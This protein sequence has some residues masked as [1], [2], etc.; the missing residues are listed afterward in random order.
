MQLY[1]RRFI[2]STQD[3]NFHRPVNS[4]PISLVGTVGPTGPA[5]AVGPAG[6]AGPAGAIG[7]TGEAG[8]AGGP[9]GEV[10]PVGP[11]GEVGP[12]GPAGEVGPVG[13]AGEVGPVGPAGEV[14]PVGPAGEV[15]PAGPA[16]EVGPVG[17]PGPL[18]DIVLNCQL[19]MS[20]WYTSSAWECSIPLPLPEGT[21]CMLGN[22]QLS[23]SVHCTL[24][25]AEQSVVSLSNVSGQVSIYSVFS[26]SEVN[27][28]SLLIRDR[29][30][31]LAPGQP[32]QTDETAPHLT[33]NIQIFKLNQLP[34][35]IPV[36]TPVY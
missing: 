29:S 1:N 23:S 4:G 28:L 33:T 17:P 2:R 24:L 5:G 14:G 19:D 3:S 16:G 10:G 36:P 31:S 25:N 8:P 9:A 26:L 20:L 7:P 12:A 32:T 15:G 35:S 30:G 11:A 18:G 27:S 21:Y 22:I 13:P 34:S 6:K